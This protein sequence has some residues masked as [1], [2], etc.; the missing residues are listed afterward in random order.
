MVG[1]SP[2]Q[3]V[4]SAS[5][6]TCF[7]LMVTTGSFN[8]AKFTVIVSAVYSSST[9]RSG[10]ENNPNRRSSSYARRRN[11]VSRVPSQVTSSN[12][13]LSE[14]TVMVAVPYPPAALAPSVGSAGPS[15]CFAAP[16]TG[17][18]MEQ[19]VRS[20]PTATRAQ[21]PRIIMPL[22]YPGTEREERA[23]CHL[24]SSL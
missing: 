14:P 18:E 20:K 24:R 19:P 13:Q 6:I 11:S 15:S 1:R 10:E 7:P 21:N 5:A 8:E 3:S 2:D 9:P 4:I 22:S 16:P 23:I 17:V 12:V